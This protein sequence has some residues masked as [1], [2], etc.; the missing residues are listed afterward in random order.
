[1]FIGRHSETDVT[2]H[3]SIIFYV[4]NG[5]VRSVGLLLSLMILIAQISSGN[6]LRL[7]QMAYEMFY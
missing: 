3:L 6:H 1:M 4:L 5:S 2:C 7:Q